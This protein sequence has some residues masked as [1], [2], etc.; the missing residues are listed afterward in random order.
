M[1]NLN[2][3]MKIA[4]IADVHSNFHSLQA[5]L[6]DVD[7]IQKAIFWSNLGQLGG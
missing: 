3:K 7:A 6:E 1:I 2:P 5:V 4:I